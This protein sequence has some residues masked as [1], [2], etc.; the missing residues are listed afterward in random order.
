VT[1]LLV[2]AVLQD[3]ARLV[4]NATPSPSPPRRNKLVQPLEDVVEVVR[5]ALLEAVPADR[6]QTART[7]ATAA[8]P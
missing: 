4:L 3:R 8:K 7:Q 6:I 5:Q 2:Q 1:R